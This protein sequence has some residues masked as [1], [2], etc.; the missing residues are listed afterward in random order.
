MTGIGRYSMWG[1]VLA[2][3]V[4]WLGSAGCS[5]DESNVRA[6]AAALERAVTEHREKYPRRSWSGLRAGDRTWK[7]LNDTISEFK[8]WKSQTEV[9]WASLVES[10]S[11]SVFDD[12][13]QFATR[14]EL[15]GAAA[16]EVL[17][18]TSPLMA[19]SASMLDFE[20]LLC[21]K[22]DGFY[23]ILGTLSTVAEVRQRV[24]LQEGDLEQAITDAE[25]MQ[26]FTWRLEAYCFENN[27]I[28]ASFRQLAVSLIATLVRIDAQAVPLARAALAEPPV[29]LKS[30]TE[31]IAFGLEFA[32]INAEEWL[33]QDHAGNALTAAELER[34]RHAVEGLAELWRQLEGESFDLTEPQDAETSLTLAATAIGADNAAERDIMLQIRWTIA[35]HLRMA[36]LAAALDLALGMRANE[37]GDN[38]GN[39]SEEDLERARALLAEHPAVRLDVVDNELWLVPRKDHPL[40]DDAAA[41]TLYPWFVSR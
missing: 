23:D 18:A 15:D 16:R 20:R 26:R 14:Y 19:V 40:A 22:P 29:P 28:V 25:Q 17:D 2:L 4:G 1:I 7:R 3:A 13:G 9:D 12:S 31:I 32:L 35:A 27:S 34:G 24:L 11:R 8:E 30:L 36:A 38:W 10:L 6:E 41:A 21:T 5:R 33:R 37:F 39:L